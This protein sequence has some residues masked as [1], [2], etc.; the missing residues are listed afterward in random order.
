MQM[1]PPA[2]TTVIKSNFLGILLATLKGIIITSSRLLLME[3]GYKR[4]IIMKELVQ[5]VLICNI[6]DIFHSPVVWLTFNYNV[7]HIH[8]QWTRMVKV[9]P[10]SVKT[11]GVYTFPCKV[12]AFANNNNI[13]SNFTAW[14]YSCDIEEG[15]CIY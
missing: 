13:C 14:W 8:L 5:G 1:L 11:P 15:V 9:I 7:S 2:V 4:A 3:I 10:S 12:K 6:L